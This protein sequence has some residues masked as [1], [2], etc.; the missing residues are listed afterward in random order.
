[1]K[2]S[3][4]E[5]LA[6]QE[7]TNKVSIEPALEGSLDN[8]GRARGNKKDRER[9]LFSARCHYLITMPFTYAGKP[10]WYKPFHLILFTGERGT[11]EERKGN[12][13][14]NPTLLES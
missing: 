2:K 3:W 13:E 8:L 7:A 14:N 10:R 6:E 12:A 4:Q 1:M 11:R 5:R 9:E